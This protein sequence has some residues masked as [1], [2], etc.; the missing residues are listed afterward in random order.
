[1]FRAQQEA[2]GQITRVVG[3][4]FLEVVQRMRDECMRRRWRIRIACLGLPSLQEKIDDVPLIRISLDKEIIE[5]D[6]NEISPVAYLLIKDI[7][8]V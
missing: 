5:I 1:M 2:S 8:I 6:T 4:T 3:A 7:Q